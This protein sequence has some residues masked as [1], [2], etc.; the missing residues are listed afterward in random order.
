MIINLVGNAIK[1]TEQ[2]EV[3]LEVRIETATDDEVVLHFVVSDTGIGIP[4]DKLELV[5]EAFTQADA[6]TTRKYGGTGLGLTISSRLVSLMG[7][8]DRCGER[9]GE[10]EPE[11]TLPLL[12][13]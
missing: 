10:G 1:F 2:G 11:Y 3:V 8:K 4:A 7:W 9:T 12:F 6:S 13:G 5:F